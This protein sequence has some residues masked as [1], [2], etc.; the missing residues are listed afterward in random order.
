MTREVLFNLL[1]SSSS[2]RFCHKNLDFMPNSPTASASAWESTAVLSFANTFRSPSGKFRAA[3]NRCHSQK[4][5]CVKKTGQMS[6]DRCLRLE[7]TCN[8]SCRAPRIYHKP[9]EQGADL[10][11]ESSSEPG[12][13]MSPNLSTTMIRNPIGSE[14]LFH[15]NANVDFS[16]GQG[17]SCPIYPNTFSSYPCS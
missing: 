16:A 5:K 11:N 3:C 8:F 9:Q 15:P 10:A 12:S 7:T 1:P 14:L 13:T 17:R 4:L 6:C 2:P